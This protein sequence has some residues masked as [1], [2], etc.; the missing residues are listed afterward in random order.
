M[1]LIYLIILVGLVKW[2]KLD[3]VS[4]ILGIN[5]GYDMSS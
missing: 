5:Q 1:N 2:I 3:Q 4:V